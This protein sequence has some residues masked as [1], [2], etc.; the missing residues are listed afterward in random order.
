VAEASL[1][2]RAAAAGFALGWRAGAV[3]DT[4]AARAVFDAAADLAWRRGGSGAARLR[5]NLRRVVGPELSDAD[6]DELTRRGL[7]SYA[8]YFRE[9]FWM[10]TARPEVVSART[11]MYGLEHMMTVRAADRGAVCALP[12]TGN[13]DAAA[14]AYLAR[15]GGSITVVAERLRPESLFQ[16]FQSY[17][18]SLGIS[19][20]PLTGEQHRSARVLSTT[21]RE[22]GMV[23]LLCDR[24]LSSSGV[25]VRFFGQ[26]ITVPPGPALLAVQTG[27]ALIPAHAGF[28]GDDWS[29]RFFP[30]VVLDGP[31]APERLRD[32]VT[33]AMQK[34]VDRF[35]LAIAERPQDWHMVQRLWA[36]DLDP[37]ATGSASR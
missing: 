9:V 20:V 36:E 11:R 21:L 24:D 17:R 3:L 19:V 10:P 30:E 32:K 1:A 16:R 8:R 13:W 23:C 35:A 4:R 28:E 7:R 14:V 33:Q 15:F 26:T 37:A 18:E 31:D 6:L 5:A 2:E 25:P 29:V 22:G 12:H 27:A 34:V